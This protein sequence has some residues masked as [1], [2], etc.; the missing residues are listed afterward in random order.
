[1]QVYL[2][3]ADLPVNIFVILAMGIAVDTSGSMAGPKLQEAGFGSGRTSGSPGKLTAQRTRM[4]ALADS[5][6]RELDRPVLDMTGLKGFYDFSL[7]WT[8]E[9]RRGAGPG[10]APDSPGPSIFTAL[11]DQLGLRLEGRKAP[12]EIMIVDRAERAP[13]EN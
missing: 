3:I 4:S 5:L 9:R 7:E 13:V 8:P 1:V 6:Y 12:V 10:E 2:P 11:R